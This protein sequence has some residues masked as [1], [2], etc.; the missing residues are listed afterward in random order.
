[1]DKRYLNAFLIP[2]QYSVGGIKLDIFCPRH[3]ITLQALESPFVVSNPVGLNYKDLFIAMRVCSTSSWSE[4]VEKPSLVERLKYLAIESISSNKSKA[5]ETFGRYMSESMSAPKV[6][7]KDD[8]NSKDLMKEKVPR[9]LSIVVCLMTKFGFSERE[10][11]DMPFSRALWYTTAFA[12]QEGAEIEVITTEQEEN[13][14]AD[15][16]KLAEYE[17]MIKQQIA[18]QKGVKK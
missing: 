9:T 1:M 7:M 4:A 18:N 17:E 11:W 3:F 8:G 16:T 12:S 14:T 2:P 5:F 10:A 6:W 13:E 15:L